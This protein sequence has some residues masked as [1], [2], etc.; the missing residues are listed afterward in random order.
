MGAVIIGVGIAVAA[1]GVV[2]AVNGLAIYQSTFGNAL[3]TVG[4]FAFVGGLT[5]LVLG[6][7]LRAL[8][9]IATKLDGVVRFDGEDEF[10]HL[11]E[12]GDEPVAVPPQVPRRVRPARAEEPLSPPPAP[13][14]VPKQVRPSPPAPEAGNEGED[15][16]ILPSWF[17]R[18]RE[19]E[20][21]PEPVAPPAV[22]VR[23][24]TLN[25]APAAD[26]ERRSPPVRREPAHDA[27]SWPDEPAPVRVP[28][29]EIS[30]PA[31]RKPSF[32][33]PPP[34]PEALEPQFLED[35]FDVPESTPELEPEPEALPA[36]PPEP[37]RFDAHEERFLSELPGEATPPP[38]AETRR[39]PK[40]PPPVTVLKSGI[41]GGMAYT[42]YSDGSI[43]AE[44]PDGVLTFASLVE[45]REHVA[46][47]EAAARQ[48][49]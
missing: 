29:P 21:D 4:G 5:I 19:P 49:D 2:L 27:P 37:R 38:A 17:R 8:K 13:V 18:K 23:R 42:L 22:A 32:P 7:V 40:A 10:D 35:D 28:E 15:E 25:D 24:P 45:L 41:I 31:A 47:S 34:E 3:V 16:T 12:E 6:F 9:E 46:A 36:A 1:M 26:A 44:L 43:Q 20:A 39:L 11:D 30:A 33:P 14:S 48:D